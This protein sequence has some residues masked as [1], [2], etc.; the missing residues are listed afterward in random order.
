MYLQ[1]IL[2]LRAFDHFEHVVLSKYAKSSKVQFKVNI[3]E[4]HT[5]SE[6][7]SFPLVFTPVVNTDLLTNQNKL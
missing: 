1:K 2:S 6:N 3:S 4:L 5:C 7:I